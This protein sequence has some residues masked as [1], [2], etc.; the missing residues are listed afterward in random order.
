MSLCSVVLGGRLR[1][2]SKL[3]EGQAEKNAWHAEESKSCLSTPTGSRRDRGLTVSYVFKINPSEGV[4]H[5]RVCRVAASRH[6]A[7]VAPAIKNLQVELKKKHCVWIK[8]HCPFV[9][10]QFS[11]PHQ[12]KQKLGK[13]FGS[14]A[15]KYVS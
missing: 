13:G 5:G 7:T 2:L 1:G 4:H 14:K 11:R 9:Y 6:G 8:P 12:L 15:Q 3:Q 10:A